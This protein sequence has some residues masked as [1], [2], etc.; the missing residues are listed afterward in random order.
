MRKEEIN[1]FV[2]QIILSIFE[3]HLVKEHI[4]SVIVITESNNFISIRARIAY[5]CGPRQTHALSFGVSKYAM[6]VVKR[7]W[8]NFVDLW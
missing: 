5:C 2:F 6:I 3:V 8:R 4:I 7:H 1:S